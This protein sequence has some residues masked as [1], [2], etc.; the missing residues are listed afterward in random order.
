[1]TSGQDKTYSHQCPDL[2]K[3]VF[4]PAP[5]AELCGWLTRENMRGD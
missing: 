3:G 5:H 2:E 4:M 1:M